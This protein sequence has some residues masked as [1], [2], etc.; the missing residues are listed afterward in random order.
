MARRKSV[1]ADATP[2]VQEWVRETV[3]SVLGEDIGED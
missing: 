1:V 3:K 2:P